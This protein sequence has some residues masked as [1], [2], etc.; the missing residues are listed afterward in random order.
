MFL[1]ILSLLSLL[2]SV[3]YFKAQA[4]ETFVL[5]LLPAGLLILFIISKQVMR[6]QFLRTIIKQNLAMLYHKYCKKAQSNTEN[7][8]SRMTDNDLQQSITSTVVSIDEI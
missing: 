8:Y 6:R 3:D 1:I 7:M 5:V 2:L 4:I